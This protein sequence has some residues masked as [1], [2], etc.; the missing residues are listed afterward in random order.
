[1]CGIAAIFAIAKDKQV[2]N[3]NAKLLQMLGMIRHRG[4]SY[5]F[6]ERRVFERGA[7]GTNRLA[8]VN[9]DYAKQPIQDDFT[10]SVVVLNGEI[11]NHEM[12]REEL[13]SLGQVFTTKS[14]TEVVL[15]AFLQWGDTFVSRLDGIFAFVIYNPKDN[16]YFAARD[17]I[18]IKP[19][20][21]AKIDGA[22]VFGSERKCFIELSCEV[23]EIKPGYFF[24]DGAETCYQS[25]EAIPNRWDE[26]QA[27]GKCRDLLEAAVKRQ[28]ATDLPIA[29]IFS[30]GLDSTIILH[31]AMKYHPDVTAFSLGTSDSED[32][33]YARRFCKER[34]I[35]QHIVDFD[36]SLIP[37]T[38]SR[39]IFDGE[40]FEPVDISDM[41]S[42]TTVY[43]A[44]RNHGFKIALSG[45]GSD[46]IFSGYDM[47]KSARDPLSLTTYRV[48][49]LYRTDLQR[50]DRSSMV[51]SIE[52]RVPFLDKELMSFAMSLP[53][54]LKIRDGV[55]KYILRESMRDELP[56]Y[57]IDR[58]KI[59]MPEGIGIND[60]VFAALG[61]LIPLDYL[62]D[63]EFS[64]DSNQVRYALSRYLH[65]GFNPPS[66][67]VKKPGVDYHDG[68]YFKFDD[69]IERSG[70]VRC[71]TSKHF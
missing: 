40:F 10:G 7:I 54:D 63:V 52:G 1:M 33:D 12:L 39:A 24:R 68:G 70:G 57:M 27:I 38:I 49:N 61:E 55:E 37:R 44:A 59:R 18:G 21:Y 41:L 26:D 17:H 25:F 65:F 16:S 13:A 60:Q 5:H 35:R 67:R 22:I 56:S 31:L 9:R 46:E 29:V 6:A 64:L 66:E 4:D 62:T 47:F 28:V 53:M 58:P 20:Y 45:D 30:G 23:S 34:S 11:Y 15:R 42:M 43:A 50:V 14:D 32:L 8:I 71:S 48:N 3:L 69:S 51:N 2:N 19:L 36:P